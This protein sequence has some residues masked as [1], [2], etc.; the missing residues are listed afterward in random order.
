MSAKATERKLLLII[1]LLRLLSFGLNYSKAAI[2]VFIVVKAIPECPGVTSVR[3]KKK[4]KIMDKARDMLT[5]NILVNNK[6]GQ[7]KSFTNLYYIK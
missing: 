7:T 3:K 1:R 2:Y 6:N 5:L 4:D